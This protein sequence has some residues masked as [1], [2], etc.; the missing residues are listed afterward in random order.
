M[1]EKGLNLNIGDAVYH[2]EEYHLSNYELK[3]K[4]FDG[5]STFGI[6][7][8]TSKVVKIGAASF[9]SRSESRDIGDNTDNEYYWKLS[10]YGRTVF[11]T[12][13]EAANEADNRAH[14][15]QLGYHC[16]KYDQRPMYKNWLHWDDAKKSNSFKAE[17]AEKQPKLRSNLGK[18]KATLPEDIYIAWR[19]GE[20]SGP[21]GAKKI[22]V[23]ITTFEKYVREELAK[24]GDKHTVK[25]GNKIPPKPLPDNFAECFE[26]WKCGLL[27]D[28]R[29]ARQCGMSSTT[30][31][32]YARIR[33]REQGETREGV[34]RG[35]PL[36]PNFTD[37]YLD[38]EMG[39]IS[40]SEAARQCGL[41]Y[42][43]FKYHAEKRYNE[44]MEAGVFQY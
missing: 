30:F 1:S 35:T 8:V 12:K 22:G 13:E 25:T 3:R 29:A 42:Y 39:N 17:S 27:S 16:S 15:I 4:G 10:E 41:E 6:E 19:D 11:A 20:L 24:R 36:P 5:F 26:Q 40:C 2:V 44:R 21:A 7:V 34:R 37:V 14:D 33:L 18:R 9:I 38:W 43:V 28:D 32:K 31:G 23:S